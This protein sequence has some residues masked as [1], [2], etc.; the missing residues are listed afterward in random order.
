MSRSRAMPTLE[1]LRSLLL[2]LSDVLD[3]RVEDDAPP[4]WCERRGW[5][6]FL[7]GLDD[8]AL[9][10]CEAEGP[11]AR[12][13]S[14]AGV[15]PDLAALA[16]E[17]DAATR[18][19]ELVVDAR[20]LPAPSTR[21]VTA[22]KRMQLPALLAAV[23][24]M[25]ERAARIVDVGAGS[26]H[27]TRIAAET[28]GREAVGIE[29]DPRRVAWAEERAKD[30]A[31]GPGAARFV[32]VDA[33]RGALSLSPDDLAVGLHACG[34]LGDRLA[35]AAG[36][37]GCDLALV[38]CC[39]QK[40]AGPLR[41]PLSRAAEGLS[42]ARGMLGLANLTRGSRRA[43]RRA[44]ARRSRRGRRASPC[45]ACSPRVGSRSRPARRCGASTGEGRARGSGRSRPGRSRSAG[46]RRRR[47]RRS[48]RHEEEARR[49][50]AAV[51]RLSLP[52]SM[53]ARLVEIA[54]VL[55]RAAALEE[56]GASVVVATL[57]ERSASPRNVA[58]LA[59]RSPGRLPR[60]GP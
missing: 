16:A 57:F 1:A 33:C 52:R 4:P 60:I 3:G 24:P 48:A 9:A 47:A 19:P 25:A 26:G 8:R 58:I 53:L 15:P 34:E 20:A 37:A 30:R 28:F 14:I 7:L 41:A 59:S 18:I 36:E 27:F 13:P 2:P 11:A 46:S 32:A 43:W 49:R 31:P 55:D 44:S 10:R 29:R 23:G 40:I 6:G 56:R 39:L 35:I 45:G 22:R 50:H 54:V 12:L 51:R 38:S 42:F 5:T 21:A 17:V